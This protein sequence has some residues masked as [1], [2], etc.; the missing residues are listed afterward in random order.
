[1]LRLAFRECGLSLGLRHWEGRES[2]LDKY[3]PLSFEI[4]N[5]WLVAQS[6]DS[7][8]ANEDINKVTLAASLL[9]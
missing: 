2:K 1:N 3:I 8:H 5:F 4:E 6:S 7:W 9:H